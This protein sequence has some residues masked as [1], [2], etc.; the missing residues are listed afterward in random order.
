[1]NPEPLNPER[2]TLNLE[3]NKQ[4]L[5]TKAKRMPIQQFVFYIFISISY[6]DPAGKTVRNASNLTVETVNILGETSPI[7]NEYANVYT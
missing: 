4:P 3:P 7:T 2:R 5:V 6:I 1:M